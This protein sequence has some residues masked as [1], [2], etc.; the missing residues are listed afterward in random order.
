MDKFNLQRYNTFGV[1]ATCT[2]IVHI[3]SEQ[4]VYAFLAQGK[5][6][7]TILGGGSN[8][9]F[10]NDYN[11]FI[12]KIEIKGIEVID[13][14]DDS[15]LVRVGAGEIW[16]QFVQWCVHHD[17]GGLENL[18]LIP[19]SVGAAPIQNIG[20]YGVEQNK[21]FHSLQ[22]IDLEEGITKTVYKDECMF[23][24]RDS[25]FK[26]ELKDKVLITRVYYL[27]KK[28]ASP[29]I[30]YADVSNKLTEQNIMKPGIAD[31]AEAVISI[32]SAKLP[33]PRK[34]G[35]A[36]SFFKNP[37][38]SKLQFESISSQHPNIAHYPAGDHVKLAAA[39]LIDQCG[40]K[41][42]RD[43]NTGSYKNQALVIVNFGGATG[44]EIY[45]Y[46]VKIQHSVKEKFGIEMEME[47]NII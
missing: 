40:F 47:V 18:S 1:Q 2:D 10:V 24:Y 36:G 38:I 16:H 8:I 35:N 42:Y 11:G 30:S 46:A 41:G 4:D 45:D 28:Y 43:G 39:W 3:Y 5:T 29:T 21:C 14:D 33:D 19:G 12:V 44:K 22:Y 13:E 7:F 32:R 27:L 9:L 37:V 34:I 23:G 6:P 31:V 17:L 20:A 26:H 25:V 15:I